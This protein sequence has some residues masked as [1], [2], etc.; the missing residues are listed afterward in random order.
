MTSQLTFDLPA[1][2]TWAREDFLVSPANAA[3]LQGVE[4]WRDWSGGSL[5]LLGPSGSG[6][7]HLAHI[8]AE[9]S[10]ALWLMPGELEERLDDIPAEACIL[11]ENAQ[12]VA[13]LAEP[14]LLHLYNRLAPQG[15]L[16]LTAPNAPRDWGLRLPDLLSR[17]QAIPIARLD[18]PDDAL[19]AGVLVKLLADRQIMAQPNLISYLLPRMERSIAAARR[20]VAALDA[21]SLAT[22]RPVTRSLAAEVLD[23]PLTE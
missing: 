6:K 1:A 11:I 12:D 8:W 18:T 9:M 17:L 23:T 10:Q 5:L 19:L 21:R 7:T 14:A 13:G 22:R 3:A 20:V 16:L 4:G 2:E 15:R